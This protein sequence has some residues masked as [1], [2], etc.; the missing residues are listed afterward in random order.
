[1]AGERD[2]ADSGQV[3]SARPVIVFVEPRLVAVEVAA[4]ML[5][6]SAWSVRQLIATDE[7]P[8]MTLGRRILIPVAQ[9]DAWLT[10]RLATADAAHTADTDEEAA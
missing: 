8:T 3:L 7:L 5:G 9:L 1:M 4:R 2:L 10:A 6:I